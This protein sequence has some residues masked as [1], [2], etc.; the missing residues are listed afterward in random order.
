MEAEL[1]N[2][3][4][5]SEKILDYAL[6][7]GFKESA[8]FS[9]WF[10]SKTR[11]SK[12]SASYVWSRSDSPWGRFTFRITN[13]DTNVEAEITR[14]SETDVLVVFEDRKDN[15]V[16]LH[17]ENKLANGKFTKY[18]PEFYQQRAEA[19]LENEKFGRYSDYETVLVAPLE[20]YRNN[21]PESQHF[22]KYVSYEEI[23][24]LLPEF[25]QYLRQYKN[26]DLLK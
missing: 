6:E 20:F 17:I 26:K 8:L 13:N 9:N 18:Q 7:Q 15:R 3:K 16:A 23:A 21:F 11:F 19:W 14:D 25:A 1:S 10:L 4:I 12:I 22:N 5:F 2:R 24:I